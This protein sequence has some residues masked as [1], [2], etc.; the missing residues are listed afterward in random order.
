M[1][2]RLRVVAIVTAADFSHMAVFVMI[3]IEGNSRT[4][5]VDAEIVRGADVPVVAGGGIVRVR[6]E[7]VDAVVVRTGIG[8]VA[9]FR[10]RAFLTAC[11]Q[12]VHISVAVVIDSVAAN[13]IA[14]RRLCCSGVDAYGAKSTI[15][16]PASAG[17]AD[18][19]V[20]RRVVVTVH[21]RICAQCRRAPRSTVSVP[22]RVFAMT[23]KRVVGR[24]QN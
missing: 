16:V 9:V 1:D 21:L 3:E 23:G 14:V 7:A 13:G 8:V 10:D 5:S 15:G 20:V 19:R 11:I 22:V 6:A 24:G 2:A 12:I 4:S 17:C 18:G